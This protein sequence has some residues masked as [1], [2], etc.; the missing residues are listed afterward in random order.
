MNQRTI[1]NIYAEF[2]P[3]SQLSGSMKAGEPV[4]T[5]PCTN[6]WHR[7]TLFPSW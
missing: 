5:V 4:V 6:R 3:T 2:G 7:S 1:D